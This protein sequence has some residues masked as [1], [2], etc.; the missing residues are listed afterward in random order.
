MCVFADLMTNPTLFG[1]RDEE[2]QLE[3]FKNNINRN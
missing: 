1:I 2:S 3:E